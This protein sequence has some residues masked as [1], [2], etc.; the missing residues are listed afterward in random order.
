[1]PAP[2]RGVGMRNGGGRGPVR[3][4]TRGA[5]SLEP[6]RRKL[7]GGANAARSDGLRL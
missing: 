6:A 3:V 1:M 2:Q 7:A 4:V 5:G